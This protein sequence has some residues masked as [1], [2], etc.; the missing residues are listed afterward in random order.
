MYD[1]FD[2]F[3]DKIKNDFCMLKEN[4]LSK[5]VKIYLRLL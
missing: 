1:R 4:I 5:K 2:C 3:V